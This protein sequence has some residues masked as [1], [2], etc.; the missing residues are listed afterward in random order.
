[1]GAFES[2][3]MAEFIGWLAQYNLPTDGSADFADPDGDRAS[4]WQEWRCATIPTNAA[5]TLRW[6]T[7]QAVGTN[8]RLA[9]ES[10]AG[11]SYGLERGLDPVSL[12]TFRP[13]ASN[14]VVTAGLTMV[15]D[16][17]SPGTEP[18]FYRV[19]ARSPLSPPSGTIAE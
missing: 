14:I 15:L 11:V 18:R 4:N 5:S 3:G 1:M 6:L 8:M 9:W 10:I 16:T 17:N 13:L 2:Q 7:P 19:F 12:G